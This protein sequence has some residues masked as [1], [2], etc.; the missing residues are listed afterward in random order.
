MP[1]SASAL[2]AA[3]CLASIQ[4]E[5]NAKPLPSRRRSSIARSFVPN[6]SAS[7]RAV[8]GTSSTRFGIA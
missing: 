8:A 1:G 6:T 4:R 3:A 7:A 5:T 2:I